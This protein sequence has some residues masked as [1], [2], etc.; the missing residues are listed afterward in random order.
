MVA[1]VVLPLS[2]HFV[3]HFFPVLCLTTTWNFLMPHFTEVTNMRRRVFPFLYAT[4]YGG[5]KYAAKIFSLLYFVWTEN[6]PNLTNLASCNFR[7]TVWKN[8]KWFYVCVVVVIVSLRS[9]LKSMPAILP[10]TCRRVL[11]KLGQFF[12]V[13]SVDAKP[14]LPF[15][16]NAA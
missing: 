16:K 8:A 12:L 6:F 11:K 14:S 15:E 5:C 4:F 7:E 13:I 9:F 1:F 3:V 2:S 10:C